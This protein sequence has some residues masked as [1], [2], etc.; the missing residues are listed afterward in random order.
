MPMTMLYYRRQWLYLVN[1]PLQTTWLLVNLN[2]QFTQTSSNSSSISLFLHNTPLER[3]ASHKY[4]DLLLTEYLT[5][6]PHMARWDASYQELPGLFQLPN[7]EER[8][9]DLILGLLFKILHDL[10]HFPGIE[11]FTTLQNYYPSRNSHCLQLNVPFAH[12]NSY[13]HS[14]SPTPY[15]IGIL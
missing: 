15:Y 3:V 14:F 2:D 6:S 4:L 12:T 8:R 7:L 11:S 13:K 9:L 5:W 10:C 1:G